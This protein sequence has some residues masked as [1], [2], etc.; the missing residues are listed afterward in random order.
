MYIK[1]QDK[2]LVPLEATIYPPEISSFIVPNTDPESVEIDWYD[3]YREI[4]V[5]FHGGANSQ[6][7][8]IY[9]GQVA[10]SCN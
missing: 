10:F 6:Q 5:E 7:H 8:G 1:V 9:F 4:P 3:N 2:E